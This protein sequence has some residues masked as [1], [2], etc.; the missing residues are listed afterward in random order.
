[1]NAPRFLVSGAVAGAISAFA[2]AVV[3]DVLISDIWFSTVP[4]MIAGALCGASV[5]WTYALLFATASVRSWVGYNLVYLGVLALLGVASVVVF[6]PVTTVA[7]VIEANE[8]PTELFGRAMPM[9]VI[10]LVAMTCVLGFLFGRNWRHYLAILV[11]CTVLIALLG[12]NIS[13][14]GLVY[15]PSGSVY[16]IAEFVGLVFVLDAIYALGVIV[17]E[18]RTIVGGSRRDGA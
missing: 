16:L 5:G 4:M 1:M 9:T 13:A 7:A 10:F 18:R 17:I 8:P 3:H 2:F 15:V 14:L 11:T 6:D 12:L